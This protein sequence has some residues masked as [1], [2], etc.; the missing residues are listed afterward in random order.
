MRKRLP[1]ILLALIMVASLGTVGSAAYDDT[2][3]VLPELG[4]YSQPERREE[5]Y[6]GEN[7]VI[8]YGDLQTIYLISASPMDKNGL[9]L[10]IDNETMN[11]EYIPWVGGTNTCL[12]IAL[13]PVGIYDY[14]VQAEYGGFEASLT[15]TPAG[16]GGEQGEYAAYID[17]GFDKYAVGFT[18]ESEGMLMINEGNW[19]YGDTTSKPQNPDNSRIKF[20]DLT[21]AVGRIEYDAMDTPYYVVDGLSSLIDVD[22]LSMTVENTGGDAETFSWTQEGEQVT[23]LTDVE[24]LGAALYA[25]EG[26]GANAVVSADVK[27]TFGERVVE[28]TVR[29]NVFMQKGS[30]STEER[31]EDDTVESLNAYLEEEAKKLAEGGNSR[32]EVRLADTTY[33]GTIVI[34][35]EFSAQNDLFLYGGDNTIIRGGI[36]LN[37]AEAWIYDVDFIADDGKPA[38]YNGS[39]QVGRCSFQ[40]YDV[41][42]KSEISMVNPVDCVFAGNKV[43]AEISLSTYTVMPDLVQ[44]NWQRNTFLNNTTAIHVESLN[45]LV[46]PYYFRVYDSNFINNGT[47]FDVDCEGTFYFYRNYYGNSLVALTNPRLYLHQLA[48]AGTVSIF[49][50]VQF[51]LPDIEPGPR[52]RVIT[53]PRYIFPVSEAAYDLPAGAS[54][55]NSR[56]VSTA[57]PVADE[58]PYENYL[59]ADWELDTEII[60]SEAN[61]L[62]I[63]ASAFDSSSTGRKIDVVGDNG[64]IIGTWTFQEPGPAPEDGNFNAGIQVASSSDSIAVSIQGGSVITGLKPTL[65]VPCAFEN[66]AVTFS[67]IEIESDTADGYVTFAVA[68]GG[69][70]VI[71]PAEP[72]T[73]QPGTP[74]KPGV[75][76]IPSEPGIPF[77][78]VTAGQWFYDYVEYVYFN[79]LMNGTSATTFEPNASMTRAM[80]WTILARIDGETVTGANW[81]TAARTW[82]MAKGVS[83]GTDPNGLVTREQFATMLWRYAG[84]P[85]SV[86]SL[87]AFNDTGSV[88]DWAATAMAW[89]VEH[90][91]ITGMTDTTLVPQGSATRAQC[92][93]MLM[94]FMEM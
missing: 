64:Q 48:T 75:P 85:E 27:I 77:T 39:G 79:G 44:K 90:G 49:T 89:A 71:T 26:Y 19:T 51:G 6:L 54:S 46:S 43:A 12:E 15:V 2:R 80:V 72:E 31:P 45:R 16:A 23:T 41:A 1:S 57:A 34:P 94:R 10:V 73:E 35:E 37:G 5:T 47:D 81:Q 60:S 62:L 55:G 82:A 91:I 13:K 78:D 33:N 83:D 17:I 70:Y 22:V 7:A 93:A 21:V 74:D 52:T 61:S 32:L 87:N 53:N 30:T 65:T 59:T 92:A 69:D 14:L 67:G 20:R 50:L 58:E 86:H 29:I 66:A 56:L 40:G 84:E 18:F 76:S 24:G 42:L 3:E 9:S 63:D 25:K 38:V 4:F 28:D 11:L 8:S 88:S 36:D 68:A